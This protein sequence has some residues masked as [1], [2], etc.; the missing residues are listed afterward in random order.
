MS[1]AHLAGFEKLGDL[2][3][4]RIQ[5]AVSLETTGLSGGTQEAQQSVVGVGSLSQVASA[6]FCLQH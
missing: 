5:E 6:W 3:A 2:F 1:P 4:L